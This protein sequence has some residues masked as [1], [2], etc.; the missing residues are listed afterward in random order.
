MTKEQAQA[1]AK[2]WLEKL[3]ENMEI[4]DIAPC[5]FYLEDLTVLDFIFL[6]DDVEL[7][8]KFLEHWG[9]DSIRPCVCD[10]VSIL[11]DLQKNKIFQV[12]RAVGVDFENC[13]KQRRAQ[14]SAM[15][16]S[17]YGEPEADAKAE[18]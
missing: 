4:K 15:V 13:L 1:K 7:L 14:L 18:K 9:A 3:Q 16:N 2:Q 17:V 6:A 10:S 5:D 11:P 8:G 12:L